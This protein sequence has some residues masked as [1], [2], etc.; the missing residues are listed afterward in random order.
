AEKEDSF[1]G[2]LFPPDN[3]AAS[4]N[5]SGELRFTWTPSLSGRIQIARDKGFAV[6]VLDE[7]IRGASFRGRVLEPG[8]YFWRVIPDPPYNAA[9]LY[10]R[11]PSL[12]EPPLPS[13]SLVVVPALAPPELELPQGSFT[14]YVEDELVA[15]LP[16]G[17]DMRFSW[18]AGLEADYYLFRLYG[19][20]TPGQ[21]GIAPNEADDGPAEAASDEDVSPVIPGE[22]EPG[23]R[24]LLETHVVEGEYFDLSFDVYE[25]GRYH[26]SV[27][28]VVEEHEGALRQRGDAEFSS[29]TLRT[30]R[31]V[32]LEYPPEDFEISWADVM[33]GAGEFRW[34]LFGNVSRS[35]FSL[36]R[37]QRPRSG[38]TLISINNPRSSFAMPQLAPGDYYWTIEATGDDGIDVSAEEAARFTVVPSPPLPAARGLSPENNYVFGAR[39]LRGRSTISFAWNRVAGAN[40]YIFTLYQLRSNGTR[41][42]VRDSG[43]LSRTSYILGD[44]AALDRGT[45]VWQVEAVYRMNDNSIGRRG[46]LAERRFTLDASS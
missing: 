29:F 32:V 4:E 28:P 6:L 31:S 37:N 3:Y 44:L 41:R 15:V 39:E 1:R 30:S 11:D 9:F 10:A 34:S 7:A 23:F 18:K 46:L 38:R 33:R 19:S 13:H 20:G 35:R 40:A 5:L 21:D 2:L 36:A 25:E 8:R 16:R 43:P 26:W 17:R 24:R 27:Q 22:Q 45:F 42:R 14:G 12:D